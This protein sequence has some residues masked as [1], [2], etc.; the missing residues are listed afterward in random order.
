MMTSARAAFVLMTLHLVSGLI[1]CAKDRI[2]EP[3]S[4]AVTTVSITPASAEIFVDSQIQLAAVAQDRSG[5]PVGG[6][7][8]T[9][10][11]E[12]TDVATVSGA[13]LVHAHAQGQVRISAQI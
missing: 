8:V 1:G 9:W 10:I 3:G 7:P 13:G 12:D 11:S 4:G 6:R 5:Q 2:T